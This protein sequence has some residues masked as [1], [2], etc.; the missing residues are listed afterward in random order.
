MRMRMVSD[1]QLRI[2]RHIMCN[3]K[4]NA[5]RMYCIGTSG[6]LRAAKPHVGISSQQFARLLAH[7]G[8]HC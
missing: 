7:F 1:T 6:P 2:M 5:H 3:T 8:V 4:A